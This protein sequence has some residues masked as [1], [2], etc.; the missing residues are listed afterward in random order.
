M[1]LGLQGVSVVL[2]SGDSGVGGRPHQN[3]HIAGCLGNGTIFNP[4]YPGTCPYFTTAGSTFIPPGGSATSDDE[5][6]TQSFSSGGGFSNI[7]PAPSYQ[8]AAIDNYFRF[9]D[10]IV[11]AYPYYSSV[12]NVSIGANGGIYNR[13]GRGYPD[14][15]AVGDNIYV[16]NS[17][18][19]GL[20]GG[21]SASAPVFA[22]IL[23]R[24]NEERL[25]AG[26]STIGFVNPVLYAHPEAFHDITSGNNSACSSAGFIAGKGW[27]PV[28]G[29]GTPVYPKLLSVFMGLS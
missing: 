13:N 28:T 11:K 25:A 24:I 8:K 20:N 10:P 5:V 14:V 9:A 7:Y 29:L 22:S 12:N 1:K 18:R 27:D 23:N 16:V 3:G 17:G 15:A 19:P 26:K 21:T 4:D 6:A 2:A